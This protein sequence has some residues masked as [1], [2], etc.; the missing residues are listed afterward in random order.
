MEIR[1]GIALPLTS[2]M[3]HAAFLDSWTLLERPDFTYHR[4]Q[5]PM[6]STS[7]ISVVRNHIVRQA[8]ECDRTHLLTMDTDQVYPTDTVTKLVSHAER[9]LRFVGAKVHRRY[10]PFDPV[11]YRGEDPDHYTF[12]PE[13]EWKSGELIRVDAMGHACAIMDID[14]FLEME[15]PWFESDHRTEADRRMGEDIRFCHKLRKMGV[16]L[17]VDTSIKV[18]HLALMEVDDAFYDVSKMV[19]TKFKQRD[20]QLKQEVFGDGS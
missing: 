9:G 12:V 4:P 16:E 15:Y 10:P 17:W 20:E 3:V 5:F 7:D 1:L 6:N 2:S 8:L 19:Q 13:E 11:L 18:S 14:I